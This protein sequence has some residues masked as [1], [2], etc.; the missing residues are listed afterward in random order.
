MRAYFSATSYS[1]G[2]LSYSDVQNL[3]CVRR[4]CFSI[5]ARSVAEAG[6]MGCVAVLMIAS[7][8]A[9]GLGAVAQADNRAAE[10]MPKARPNFVAAGDMSGAPGILSES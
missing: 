6:R 3:A 4:S 8:C 1:F 5:S 7:S 9:V 10:A 2:F